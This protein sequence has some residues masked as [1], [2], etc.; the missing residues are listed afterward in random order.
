M[1]DPGNE[2]AYTI[3]LNIGISFFGPHLL[4]T[5]FLCYSSSIFLVIVSMEILIALKDK[6][7]Q[8]PI[9]FE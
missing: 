7:S 2:V 8:I 5:K 1:R 9:C 3:V 4:S 6:L